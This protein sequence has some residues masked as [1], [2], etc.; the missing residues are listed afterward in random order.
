[1]KVDE[2]GMTGESDEVKKNEQNPFLIGSCLVTSGSGR[3]MVIAVGPHSISGE[4]QM[5]L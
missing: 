4:I 2:S 1:M 3:E 5:T